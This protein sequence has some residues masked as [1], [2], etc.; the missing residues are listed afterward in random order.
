MYV[1]VEMYSGLSSTNID[2]NHKD[3]AFTQRMKITLIILLHT[4]LDL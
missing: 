1:D 4:V 3:K 2:A